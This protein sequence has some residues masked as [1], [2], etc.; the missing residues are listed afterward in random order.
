[1]L[2]IEPLA[3]FWLLVAGA[4]HDDSLRLAVALEVLHVWP[5]GVDLGHC[6]LPR[7]AYLL[8]IGNVGHHM[9]LILAAICQIFL[10]YPRCALIRC[11]GR[12]A[13]CLLVV[14]CDL[15]G[16]DLGALALD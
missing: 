2:V 14:R 5:S 11:P 4:E 9:I 15:L 7:H 16:L 12:L 6:V 13:T 10:D 8:Q 3:R 1:V